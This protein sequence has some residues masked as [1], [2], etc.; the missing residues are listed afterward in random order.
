M[1][2]RARGLG[3]RIQMLT[4]LWPVQH[5]VFGLSKHDGLH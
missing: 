5:W 4:V 3:L 1:G 2:L